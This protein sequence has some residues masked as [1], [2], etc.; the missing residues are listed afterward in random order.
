MNKGIIMLTLAVV[1]AAMVLIM[2]NKPGPRPESGKTAGSSVVPPAAN[3]TR[4]IGVAEQGRPV[5]T[6][7]AGVPAAPVADGSAAKSLAPPAA[8]TPPPLPRVEPP[9]STPAD[10]GSSK[11]GSFASPA[12]DQGTQAKGSTGFFTIPSSPQDTGKGTGKGQTAPASPKAQ[13]DK[14]TAVPPKT[15]T[16]TQK[17]QKPA[18]EASKESKATQAPAGKGPHT[19]KSVALQFAGQGMVLRIEAEG[20]F[21]AKA[22]ILPGPDRLVIDLAGDWKNLQAPKVPSNNLVKGARLGRQPDAMRLVLDLS[23]APKN[24][25]KVQI[26]DTVVEIRLQ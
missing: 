3:A 10:A 25:Q 24:H 23:K 17:G 15:D 1:L 7:P 6:A 19:A 16:Q 4:A 11:D 12:N 9:A 13:L 14:K 20:P 8:P 26:S 2:A 18:K 21:A 5:Q 22:Y